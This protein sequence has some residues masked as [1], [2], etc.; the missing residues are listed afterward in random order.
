M[1]LPTVIDEAYYEFSRQRRYRLAAEFIIGFVYY[2]RQP[3]VQYF[4][5]I[6]LGGLCPGGVVRVNQENYLCFFGNC[7]FNISDTY[8]K[9]IIPLHLDN[10]SPAEL[11]AELENAE[12][13]NAVDYLITG[14][15]EE[16]QNQVYNLVAAVPGHNVLGSDA[17][18]LRKHFSKP[19]LAVIRINVEIRV[20]RQRLCYPRRAAIWVLI[21]VQFYNVPDR[22]ICFPFQ[23]FGR[24]VGRIAPEA[25]QV[26]P[27][28]SFNSLLFYHFV[29]V[30]RIKLTEHFSIE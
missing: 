6:S 15:K 9:I 11:G 25:G 13:G 28:K 26:R 29:P 14:V 8:S 16:T 12:S 20:F 10:P 27:D 21:G 7:G 4:E 18:V 17:G 3:H 22:D 24:G 1:G 2:R 19:G 23:R 5:D 30:L